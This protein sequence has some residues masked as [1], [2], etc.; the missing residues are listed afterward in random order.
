MRHA[1]TSGTHASEVTRARARAHTQMC[2]NGFVLTTLNRSR[3]SSPTGASPVEHART[4]RAPSG[5]CERTVRLSGQQLTHPSKLDR[6]ALVSGLLQIS[7]AE[8]HR[9]RVTRARQRDRGG[10][11]YTLVVR[12]CRRRGGVQS[13][14][15][16]HRTIAHYELFPHGN[17]VT[18]FRPNVPANVNF[19]CPRSMSMGG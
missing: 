11:G 3:R 6:I 15:L 14:S 1:R 5:S 2:G 12:T 9:R 18:E 13:G 8:E 17:N 7:R 16:T 10:F 19:E 4:R